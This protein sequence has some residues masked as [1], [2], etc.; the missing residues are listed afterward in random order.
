MKKF[1]I[2]ILLLF[3]SFCFYKFTGFFVIQPIGAIPE[4]ATIWY[5]RN[6]TN[7]GFVESADGLM[8]KREGYVNLLGRMIVLG[9]VLE[10]LDDKRIC[11]LPYMNW[12]YLIS[13][14]GQSFER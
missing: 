11:K 13:T 4:G 14:K 7:L 1:I 12:M 3:L 2:P 9:K 5:F 10:E 8:L 6:D